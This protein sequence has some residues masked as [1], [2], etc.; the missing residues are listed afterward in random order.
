MINQSTVDM[1]III[2]ITIIIQKHRKIGRENEKKKIEKLIL[3]GV[4]PMY[5]SVYRSMDN[6]GH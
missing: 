1:M 4:Y 3:V 2:I 5:L 6:V